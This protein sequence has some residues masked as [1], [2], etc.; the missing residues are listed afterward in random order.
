M[1]EKY[2]LEGVFQTFTNS[3][4]CNG[5][6]YPKEVLE[7]ECRKLEIRMKKTQRKEK[8]KKILI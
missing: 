6:T 7:Q 4:T 2:I 3:N 8:L 1:S 5:R